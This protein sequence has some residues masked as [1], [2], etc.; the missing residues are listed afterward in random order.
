MKGIKLLHGDCLDLMK[1]IPDK[2]I[3]MILCD[4]PFGT[5]ASYWDKQIPAKKLWEHYNRIISNN[6]SVLLFA[7]GLFEP[8]VMLSNID[9]YKYKW[10]WVKNNSTNFVHAKNRPMTKH[11]SILVF[12]KAPMGHISQLG[13]KRMNYTPQGLVS[14]EKKIK[15]GNGRFG[16]VAGKRK[17]HLKSDESFTRKLTNFPTDVL[18]D[19]PD[20]PP[21]QKLHTNEKPVALL[22]YLIKTYTNEGETVLD[23][24]MGS[25]TTGVACKNLNRNF[26]GI[27]LDDKYFEI[28]KERICKEK[29]AEY[30]QQ[31]KR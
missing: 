23:N 7:S 4:L 29:V 19:F 14:C 11:E 10:V 1:D 24:C 31:T 12:S 2:S 28:A 25:G 15:Q 5:T 9:Y 22:E 17:S 3:D 8:R 13:N 16:T 27:E 30:E 18:T 21:N 26:I 6:G 20:L